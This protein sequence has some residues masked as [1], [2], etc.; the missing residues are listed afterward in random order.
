MLKLPLG[1][2]VGWLRLLQLCG[3]QWWLP[4]SECGEWMSQV[5]LCGWGEPGRLPGGGKDGACDDSSRVESKVRVCLVEL[6]AK[7]NARRW[8]L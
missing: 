2:H 5:G 8:A 3:L 7:A 6:R 1:L 4:I